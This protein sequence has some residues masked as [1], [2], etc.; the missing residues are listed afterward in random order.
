MKFYVNITDTSLN[1]YDEVHYNDY[2]LMGIQVE[3]AGKAFVYKDNIITADMD[4]NRLSEI[5]GEIKCK[6]G[7]G[8]LMSGAFMG[9][10]YQME[11]DKCIVKINFDVNWNIQKYLSED[12]EV[13][14]SEMALHNPK[15]K[16][17]VI[18]RK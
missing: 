7:T 17:I 12:I 1:F 18:I 3:D 4:Y 15:I 16:N 8:A 5:F 6:R 10:T 9:L 13:P 2:N 14:T 11:T